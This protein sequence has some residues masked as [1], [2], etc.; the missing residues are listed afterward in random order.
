MSDNLERARLR[1]KRT[2]M[3]VTSIEE[4]GVIG[5]LLSYLKRESLHRVCDQR[6]LCKG[7]WRFKRSTDHGNLTFS[8]SRLDTIKYG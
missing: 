8:F 6:Q 7:S 2:M 1:C 4:N 5:V 3:A